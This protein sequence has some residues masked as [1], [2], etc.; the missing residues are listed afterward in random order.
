MANVRAEVLAASRSRTGWRD[1]ATSP[2]AKLGNITG[3]QSSCSQRPFISALKTNF[4]SSGEKQARAEMNKVEMPCKPPRVAGSKVSSIANMF[5]NLAPAKD[6]NIHAVKGTSGKLDS[7]K[8][9]RKRINA[10]SKFNTKEMSGTKGSIK[11]TGEC[12][13]SACDN[14]G[15]S[16]QHPTLLAGAVHL[17]RTESHLARFNNA[18]AMFERLEEESKRSKGVLSPGSKKRSGSVSPMRSSPIR[19]LVSSPLLHSPRSPSPGDNETGLYTYSSNRRDHLSQKEKSHSADS[20]LDQKSEINCN[21]YLHSSQ[22]QSNS[23]ARNGG[24]TLDLKPHSDYFASQSSLPSSE[25]VAKIQDLSNMQNLKDTQRHSSN[26]LAS[27]LNMFDKQCEPESETS[28]KT[29]G[30]TPLSPPRASPVCIPDGLGSKDNSPKESAEYIVPS[31]QERV[32]RENYTRMPSQVAAKHVTESKCLPTSNSVPP[33]W[34]NKD[35]KNAQNSAA[36]AAATVTSSG[37][38]KSSA[39]NLKSQPLSG[40]SCRKAEDAKSARSYIPSYARDKVMPASTKP[41]PTSPTFLNDK[42]QHY[43]SLSA[44]TLVTA[45]RQQT[46]KAQSSLSSLS[47]LES[48]SSGQLGS[49]SD[50]PE[51][52]TSKSTTQHPPPAVI[53]EA[54]PKEAL[55]HDFEE[56]NLDSGISSVQLNDDDDD[57]DD[58]DDGGDRDNQ[59]SN[60]NRISQEDVLRFTGENVELV[61]AN[62]E[63][64]DAFRAQQA[65]AAAAAAVATTTTAGKHDDNNGFLD[66]SNSQFV[67]NI[68][69]NDKNASSMDDDLP[70]PPHL[71]NHCYSGTNSPGTKQLPHAFE[72]ASE[73]SNFCTQ[74]DQ[75]ESDP[76]E[77]L[78][79]DQYLQ[80]DGAISNDGSWKEPEVMTPEEAHKLLSSRDG[81]L[82]DEEADVVTMLLSNHEESDASLLLSSLP[83][84]QRTSG[85]FESCEKLA[86]ENEDIL[87]DGSDQNFDEDGEVHFLDDG[88]F[89]IEAPGLPDSDEDEKEACTPTAHS[90]K[91][92]KVKFSHDPIKVYSTFSVTEYDRRNDEV[93]PVSASAEYELE[94]RVEK[95][96][97]FPVELVK[98]PEGLGLSIIGMGV[99]ADAGLEKLGI[100]VKTITDGG[101]AHKDGRIQVND[102]IIEVGGKSLVG[103]TQA[104]AASVLRNT[105]GLVKFLI[106]REKDA[107][108]SEVAQLISQS[109]QAD[110]EREERRK[111]VEQELH[112]RKQYLQHQQEESFQGGREQPATLSREDLTLPL[113]RTISPPSPAPETLLLPGDST[114]EEGDDLPT[115]EVFDLEDESSESPSPDDI[116]T[117][118]IKMKEAQYK[119]AVAEAELAKIKSRLVVLENMS[120]TKDECERRL[121]DTSCRLE[122]VERTLENVRKEV[123]TYQDMLEESQGQYIALEKKYYK[124]KKLIRQFQQRE[125]NFYHREDYNVMQQQ[126]K[127][128]E[129][130]ALVKAL[131]DMVIQLEQEL[132]E[133]QRVAGLPVRLPFDSTKLQLTPPQEMKSSR[134]TVEPALSFTKLEVDFSDSDLSDGDAGKFDLSPDSDETKSKTSTV[135]RKLPSKLGHENDVFQKAVPETELLDSTAAK[136]KAELANKGSLANRQPPSIKKTPSTGSSESSPV[137]ERRN[138]I[139][140]WSDLSS[141]EDMIDLHSQG[142]LTSSIVPHPTVSPSSSNPSTSPVNVSNPYKVPP[143]PMLVPEYGTARISPTRTPSPAKDL[144]NGIIKEVS[145]NRVSASKPFDQPSLL[146]GGRGDQQS[147]SDDSASPYKSP[148]TSPIGASFAAPKTAAAH[149]TPS[150]TNPLR[151]NKKFA[152]EIK[153][154]VQRMNADGELSDITA[155]PGSTNSSRSTSSNTTSAGDPNVVLLSQRPL[156]STLPRSTK[157]DSMEGIPIETRRLSGTCEADLSQTGIL[158]NTSERR[159]VRWHSG[160]VNG[161]SSAQVGQWLMALGMEQYMNA[162]IDNSVDGPELLQ[163]ESSKMKALGVFNSGDRSLLKKKLKELKIQAEKERKAYEKELKS[164]EKQQKKADKAAEKASKKK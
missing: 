77:C 56:T 58:D 113:S 61:Y 81:W 141:S 107:E 38:S 22:D 78:H 33:H 95:M 76:S 98:G 40:N 24:L 92:D 39:S 109:L 112:Q 149:P 96:D 11:P 70:P 28:P 106:G 31:V 29:D 135:E 145:P 17:N 105:S 60:L 19:S 87:H 45:S 15:D 130:N 75:Y 13:V 148:V 20:I 126:E 83:G 157:K 122:E 44:T 153:M 80:D 155:S 99:G 2:T 120:S 53:L 52:G 49:L 108:N 86:E 159:F 137:M 144:V 48:L 114:P 125:D 10:E 85:V 116:T 9:E 152:E 74:R 18:R 101:A 89:W 91:R 41:E 47:S 25:Y 102:Q 46:L 34:Q 43:S 123:M 36:V 94:K 26:L 136:S 51:V 35:E 37:S 69:C 150:Q 111:A 140:M 32:R 4:E 121:H 21:K 50:S 100:F 138:S 7:P 154:V 12:R 161:W 162:F 64:I 3:S 62:Q 65:A 139:E 143:P 16:G 8:A 88:H 93:D 124:A 142:Q 110:R 79:Q 118:K 30:K 132:T 90:K 71:D 117:I 97:V 67:H 42:Q 151:L 72:G 134:T 131:K 103:V 68:N 54:L 6:E 5:Q 156:D 104:Y 133:T 147:S 146:T 27:R 160:P 158:G 164:R 128:Q 127:D 63:T 1:T 23:R 14:R 119:S 84:S 163:L 66:T 59:V 115:C 57:D 73:T 55:R 82:N 129:Y